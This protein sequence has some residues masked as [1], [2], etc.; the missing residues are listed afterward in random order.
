MHIY[1]FVSLPENVQKGNGPGTSERP[2]A[3]NMKIMPTGK[4]EAQIK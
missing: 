1:L 3:S 2:M 4:F